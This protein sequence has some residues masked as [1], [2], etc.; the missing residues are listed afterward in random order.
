MMLVGE[1][2]LL[3]DVGKAR[4]REQP[5]MKMRGRQKR[6]GEKIEVFGAGP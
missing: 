5:K 1:G 4:G 6:E 3:V 2:G